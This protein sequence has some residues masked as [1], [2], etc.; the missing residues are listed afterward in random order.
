MAKLDKVQASPRQQAG[1]Q[2]K[3]NSGYSRGNGLRIPD[4]TPDRL[5]HL[6]GLSRPE[7]PEIRRMLE[8]MYRQSF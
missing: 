6:W 4:L 8:R 7:R 2:A 3:R 1:G 5:R